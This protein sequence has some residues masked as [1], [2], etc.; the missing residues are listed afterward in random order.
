MR[1]QGFVVGA[2][3]E[4]GFV[5]V[6]LGVVVVTNIGLVA[7]VFAVV[8][9]GVTHQ[10]FVLAVLSASDQNGREVRVVGVSVKRVLRVVVVVGAVVVGEERVVTMLWSV[11]NER[12]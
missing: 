9:S 6:V 11:F 2:F 1:S 10:G 12:G 7:A 5:V 3:V 8:V 4:A